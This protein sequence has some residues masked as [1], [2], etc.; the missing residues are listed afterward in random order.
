MSR[1]T[2]FFK[3]VEGTT[4]FNV[5]SSDSEITY[6]SD[7]YT[8]IPVGRTNVEVKNELSKANIE[9]S[10]PIGHEISQRYMNTVVDSIVSL[11][12]FQSENGTV[13]VIWKGRLSAV[14]PMTSTVKLI[15]ESIFTSMRRPGLRRRMQRSCPHVL[16]GRGCNLDKEDFALA[17]TATD[18]TQ[19]TYLVPAAASYD[20]NWFSGGILEAPDL[21]LRF[22]T[23]HIGAEI[24]LIRRI[25]SLSIAIATADQAVRLFPGCNRTTEVCI[26][27]FDNLPNNG[28]FPFIPIR[29]P[30]NGQSFS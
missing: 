22:I 12:G 9:L 24:T 11:T 25:D 18:A 6:L 21:T 15:F 2:E 7:V 19:A 3:I 1:I 28:S 8:P 29:N 16:Y 23:A 26:A 14:K 27:K 30:F 17:M 13:S 20:D 5:T 10:F 4:I